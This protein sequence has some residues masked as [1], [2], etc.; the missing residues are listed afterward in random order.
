[1]KTD[2]KTFCV[3]ML[4]N[5][6]NEESQAMNK[7]RLLEV[8]KCQVWL[9]LLL[10]SFRSRQRFELW[11][12]IAST[13]AGSQRHCADPMHGSWILSQMVEKEPEGTFAGCMLWYFVFGVWKTVPCCLLHVSTQVGLS[14]LFVLFLQ[15]WPN[16]H[17][18]GEQME[19]HRRKQQRDCSDPM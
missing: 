1:M 4:F 3:P 16:R 7:V 18:A 5:A 10:I 12:P 9:P 6:A 17:E 2:E 13:H 8:Y 15:G 19:G 14:D 11:T